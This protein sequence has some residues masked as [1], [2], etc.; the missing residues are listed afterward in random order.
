MKQSKARMEPINNQE[1]QQCIDLTGESDDEGAATKVCVPSTQSTNVASSQADFLRFLSSTLH[2][3]QP[4]QQ[5]QSNDDA[6]YK[7]YLFWHDV[8]FIGRIQLK[9]YW[10][11]VDFAYYAVLRKINK[12]DKV[13]PI[14][15]SIIRI[16]IKDIADVTSRMDELF[17]EI[18]TTNVRDEIPSLKD[19]PFAAI[20]DLADENFWHSSLT[21]TCEGG[22]KFRPI[23]MNGL[24]LIKFLSPRT[25]AFHHWQGVVITVPVG[26]FQHIITQLRE[27]DRDVEHAEKS[28][29][30]SLGA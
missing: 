1:S 12:V 22:L 2:N 10:D 4:Q 5:P 3:S 6:I 15:D 24:L 25:S 19:N 8:P 14:K 7:Q 9:Q 11:P 18:D 30:L 13:G 27:F 23:R 20:D 26:P 28:R 17:K 29:L 16:P 21:K